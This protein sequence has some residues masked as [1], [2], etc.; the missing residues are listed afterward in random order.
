MTEQR[1]THLERRFELLAESAAVFAEW[2]RLAAV[3]GVVGKAAHDARLVAQMLVSQ[4]P[5]VLT[6]NTNDFRRYRGITALAPNEFLQQAA[7]P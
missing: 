3:H 5:M 4:I 6:F 7:V 1:L 2:K